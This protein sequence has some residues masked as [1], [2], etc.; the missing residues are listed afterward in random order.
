MTSLLIFTLLLAST[1]VFGELQSDFA[2]ITD[3]PWMVLVGTPPFSGL[4]C[5][6]VIVAPHYVLTSSYCASYAQESGSIIWSGSNTPDWDGL[7]HKID[8]IIRYDNQNE[9]DDSSI[10][11]LIRVKQPFI[12]KKKHKP[13][14]LLEEDLDLNVSK[15]ANIT[16]WGSL[17]PQDMFDYKLRVVRVDL[18]SEK[19]CRGFNDTKRGICVRK[20]DS[21]DRLVKIEGF[22]VPLVINGSLIGLGITQKNDQLK[23]EFI[24][25]KKTAPFTKWIHDNTDNQIYYSDL[26]VDTGVDYHVDELLV[27]FGMKLCYAA[28][29]VWQRHLREMPQFVPRMLLE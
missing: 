10:F 3:H 17:S 21:K 5:N 16:G 2:E 27:L 15:T 4:Q 9:I 19:E 12:F 25:F 8:E 13:I 20:T 29:R 1:T 6:G 18:L 23:N 7:K 26:L 14:S 24:I 11:A 22:S 28:V